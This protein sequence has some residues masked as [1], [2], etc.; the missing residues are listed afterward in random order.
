MSE[1]KETRSVERGTIN[2]R[3][4][5]RKMHVELIETLIFLFPINRTHIDSKHVKFFLH[6]KK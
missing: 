4:E 3:E 2:G 1:G 6:I 5:H